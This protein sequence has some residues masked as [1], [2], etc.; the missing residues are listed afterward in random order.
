MDGTHTVPGAEHIAMGPPP[1]IHALPLPRLLLAGLHGGYGVVFVVVQLL[2]KPGEGGRVG[3]AMV[4][5]LG[6]IGGIAHGVLVLQ[7]FFVQIAAHQ[8]CLGIA[9][10]LQRVDAAN[11][12]R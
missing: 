4:G 11:L 10:N 6:F 3:S 9:G 1:H 8:E 12:G 2:F 7:R 5:P